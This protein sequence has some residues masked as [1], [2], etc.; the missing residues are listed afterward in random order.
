MICF[1][2]KL[3]QEVEKNKGLILQNYFILHMHTQN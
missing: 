3:S 1:E 2:K